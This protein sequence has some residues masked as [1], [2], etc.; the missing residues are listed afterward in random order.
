VLHVRLQKNYSTLYRKLIV[1]KVVDIIVV[2]VSEVWHLLYNETL[3]LVVLDQQNQNIFSRQ[4]SVWR[5]NINFFEFRSAVMKGDTSVP[6]LHYV[7]NNVPIRFA[8]SVV[9]FSQ[10]VCPSVC[11]H[12]TSREV[13]SGLTLNLAPESFGKICFRLPVLVKIGQQ[14]QTFYT[15]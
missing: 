6:P 13:L 3:F 8:M 9:C 15:T 14:W 1:I 4:L 12:V 11:M 2:C 7:F 5:L 10:P